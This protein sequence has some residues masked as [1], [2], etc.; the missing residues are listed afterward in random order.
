M[1]DIVEYSGLNRRRRRSREVGRG[2]VQL[3]VGS[4]LVDDGIC[5]HDGGM[6]SAAQSRT[7]GEFPKTPIPVRTVAFA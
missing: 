5:P 3:R 1:G 4:G 7:W 2:G 6:Q